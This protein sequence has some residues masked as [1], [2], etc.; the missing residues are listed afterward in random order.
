MAGGKGGSSTTSVEVPQYIE[1]AAK[2]NLRQAGAL[3]QPGI[4]QIGYVPYYGA[5]VAA[6]TPTQ[7]A[8]FQNVAGQAGAFGLTTPAGGAMAGMPTPQEFAG[9]VRGYSSAPL[10]EQS[11]G[12]FARR[13]PAQ[14]N[15]IE[16]LFINPVTGEF[17]GA[18]VV[19]ATPPPPTAPIVE[20]E[21][22]AFTVGTQ[23]PDPVVTRPDYVGPIFDPSTDPYGPTVDVDDVLDVYEDLPSDVLPP[24]VPAVGG[25]TPAVGD[26]IDNE[27]LKQQ[28]NQVVVDAFEQFG[29]V[30][31][32]PNLTA[33]QIAAANPAF[34]P[35]IAEAAKDVPIT[36][37]TPQGSYTVPA[38]ELGSAD[39]AAATGGTYTPP[40]T[41]SDLGTFTGGG[42]GDDVADIMEQYGM[43]GASASAAGI[44][45][46]GG[47]YAQSPAG[48]GDL[49]ET[50]YNPETGQSEIIGVTST[51]EDTFGA[52]L[53]RS[54]TDPTYDPE[55]TVLSRALDGLLTPSS[56]SSQPPK[57]ETLGDFV[58]AAPSMGMTATEAGIAYEQ[59]KGVD[60]RPYDP[61]YDTK[62]KDPISGKTLTPFQL[63]N[64]IN[65][66]NLGGA[67]AEA[68]ITS[69]D[70]ALAV[71]PQVGASVSTDLPA[72]PAKGTK[73]KDPISGKTL[74]A[75]QIENRIKSPNLGKA[76]AEAGITNLNEL[77]ALAAST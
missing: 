35:E 31:N 24:I 7:E 23:L 39:F 37:N 56:A 68:G 45:N 77:L 46:I 28:Q 22:P 69:L 65:S 27:L 6:F 49:V 14:F 29:D 50:R 53:Y 9:G 43:A 12:E 15:L 42:T 16:S 64:R 72:P 67:Y 60:D 63:N 21:P 61:F 73:I 30:L 66:P 55:G 47:A 38:G 48:S 59:S 4:A 11:L 58:Q 36:I 26:I 51:P 2:F 62:V 40:A 17:E 34:N 3:G 18:P 44:R 10:Y 70:Q 1:D 20:A 25:D 76:Y 8:A 33:E 41:P 32:N 52:D 5:D 75:S 19:D 57:L 13:R 74:T 71:S 54:L